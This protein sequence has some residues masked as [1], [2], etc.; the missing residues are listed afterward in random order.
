MHIP[1]EPITVID[2]YLAHISYKDM[3][4]GAVSE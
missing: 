3:I 4:D 2:T 1:R